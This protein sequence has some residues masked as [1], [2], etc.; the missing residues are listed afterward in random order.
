M[1]TKSADL[2]P[3]FSFPLAGWTL[4][5]TAFC[6][7]AGVTM[8]PSVALAQ[9]Q[10]A[11]MAAAEQAA[12]EAQARGDDV[13]SGGME[14]GYDGMDSYEM[15]ME[16]GSGY[17][18]DDPYGGSGYGGQSNSGRGANLQPSPLVMLELFNPD[19]S[20]LT[21]RVQQIFASATAPKTPVALGPVLRNEAHVAYRYGNLPLAL[22]LFHGF[23]AR[24]SD[25]AERQMD[26]IKFSKHFRK[27]LW[28]LRIGTSLA[29][30][31]DSSTA[32]PSPI[33]GS[34]SSGGMGRGGMS[35]DDMGMDSG[36]MEMAMGSG[37]EPGMMGPGM[38]GPGGPGGP[39]GM[40]MSGE[41]PMD[42]MGMYDGDMGMSGMGG[43][44]MG[45]PGMGMPGRGGRNRAAGMA[46]P[47]AE[48]TDKEVDSRLETLLG[49]VAETVKSGL[50]KR[51]TEGKFGHALTDVEPESATQ[52]HTVNGD[53]VDQAAKSMWIPSVLFVGEGNSRET[54]KTAH[55]L[56]L[57]LLFHFDIG[58]KENRVGAV[59][60]I[61][62]L[63]V[64]DARTGKTLVSSGPMDNTEVERM[65][66]VGRGSP[67]AYVDEQLKSLWAVVDERLTLSDLPTLSPE[68]ARK[69]VAQVLGDS[70]MTPLRKLAEI[71]YYGYRGWL[72]PEEVEQAFEITG[73]VDAMKV[74]HGSD[75]QAIEAIHKMVVETAAKES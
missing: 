50:S 74:L 36:M 69:R 73:G 35:P 44:G 25:A 10:Q 60:N 30:H 45:G 13:S 21:E 49:L 72:T 31:G 8:F 32:N 7:T 61:S 56:G 14:P 55:E 39:N 64:L 71:R 62:R 47:K 52:G 20:P 15:E 24:G 70:S 34:G 43:P 58:L 22:Q 65:T 29:V 17:G 67:S 4:F 53:S 6:L 27:P 2:S 57:D 12:M 41:M 16:M 23:I 48:M 51:I 37:M 66:R 63:K 28:H 42:D 11:A 38:M 54:I 68:V 18:M 26:Q 9:G 5:L 19:W 1:L 75:T 40:G 46:V 33:T 59:S 3:R